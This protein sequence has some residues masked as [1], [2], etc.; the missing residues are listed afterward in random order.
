[1][2]VNFYTYNSAR[3]FGPLLVTGLILGE[4]KG[5]KNYLAALVM[6]LI[7][8][9]PAV[10]G[11][12]SGSGERLAKVG[13]Y[14]SPGVIGYVNESRGRCEA[15]ARA[16]VVCRVI[17]NR[18]V[19][20]GWRWLGNYL[21][22]FNLFTWVRGFAN[23]AHYQMPDYGWVWWWQLPL[24]L[25]GLVELVK[26]VKEYWPIALW[27]ALAPVAD[28]LTGPIHP[29]RSLLFLPVVIFVLT[30]GIGWLLAKTKHRKIAAGVFLFLIIVSFGPFAKAYF[31]SYPLK[32]EWNWQGGYK[33]L[34]ADLALR[35]VN[36]EKIYVTKFYGEPHIFYLFFR[37]IDPSFL[38]EPSNVVRYT[39]EDD[40]VNVD[41]IGRYYFREEEDLARVNDGL[42][43]TKNERAYFKIND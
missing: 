31:G 26:K 17:Y 25:M 27:G 33:Q 23:L 36:Y 4:R 20:V 10:A 8:I 42:V 16:K 3:V 35:E 24:I 15:K 39:R 41:R 34:Y 37:Q 40:W 5:V 43:V 14:N 7:L 38:F 28:S 2:V 32:K 12:L 21:S 13:L 11:G 18:P 22:H 19:V 6:G 30:L 9:W 1:M 29:V